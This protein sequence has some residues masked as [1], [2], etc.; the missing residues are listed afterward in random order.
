MGQTITEKIL[1]SHCN[2]SAVEP[3]ELITAKLDLVLSNDITAPIA[4]REF[5]QIGVDC[6][7]DKEKIALVPDHYTPAKD[8]KSAQQVKTMREFARKYGVTHFWEIG[9]V[10]IE[11]TLLPD[12]G[13]RPPGRCD[14]RRRLAHL[15]VWRDRRV[16]D[17]RRKHRCRIGDGARRVLVQGAGADQVRLPRQAR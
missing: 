15:H 16:L 6:V 2:R 13:T 3:G 4:I 10:G 17:R 8:I 9:R 14:H 12:D 11:H 7:F 1:A 5:A